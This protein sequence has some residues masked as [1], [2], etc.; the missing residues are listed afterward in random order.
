MPELLTKARSSAP[1]QRSSAATPSPSPGL[2]DHGATKVYATGDL[3]VTLG[4][5]VSA[6]MKAVIDGDSSPDLHFP[7][8]R[9]A[10]S[11]GCRPARR[12]ADQQHRH[13]R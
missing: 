13:H 4:V 9:G 5:A 3:V 6:A 11:C 8:K 1:R 12:T 10:I 7:Q 2:G